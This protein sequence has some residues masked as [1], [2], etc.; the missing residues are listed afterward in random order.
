MIDAILLWLR[1][2]GR[3]LSCVLGR[4]PSSLLRR[5]TR[6]CQRRIWVDDFDGWARME[7][8]LNE[9]MQRRIF[10][11][12]YYNRGIVAVLDGLLL[13]GMVV[14]DAG[15]NVG[16][17]SLVASRRVGV[18]GR[19][20]AFEPMPRLHQQLGLHTKENGL[21]QLECIELALGERSSDCQ[22]IYL[23]CG[24]EGTDV[25]LGLGSLV[26]QEGR[27]AAGNVRVV[28]LDSWVECRRLERL[29][30]IKIDVEGS[31]MA[32]LSGASRTLARFRPRIVIEIQHHT[33]ER[34][35]H[36]SHDVF[37]FLQ[38][39]GYQMQRIGD[40]GELLSIAHAGE[41]LAYQNVLCI[42]APRPLD[43]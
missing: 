28:T 32:L 25:N 4:G 2:L 29:D 31:E 15:A 30:L 14:V 39:L 20:Y 12:G 11:M 37:G 35:G 17:I 21:F 33:A 18:D 38:G 27:H 7:L 42:P 41:L 13:P 10:W 3:K 43:A 9:H 6:Y 23:D 19:V 1:M 5:A 26:E 24:Q 22:P 8:Q 16:E 34:A 36:H 40:D